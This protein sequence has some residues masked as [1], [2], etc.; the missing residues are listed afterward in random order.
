MTKQEIEQ[1]A[2]SAHDVV[3]VYGESLGEVSQPKFDELDELS[4]ETIVEAV[5][6]LKSEEK[7]Y[8]GSVHN[9]WV[10]KMIDAGWVHGKVYDIEAKTHPD[11][12]DYRSLPP[13]QRAK[14][15]LFNSVVRIGAV[16]IKKET[17]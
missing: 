2:R 4:K 1:I 5:H 14:D 16:P 10:N 13:L 15:R 8:A 12:I 7:I 11:M 9:A 3:N 17:M 6:L